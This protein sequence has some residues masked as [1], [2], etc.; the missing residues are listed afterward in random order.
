M[1]DEDPDG[2]DKVMT[3]EVKEGR[4]H[5]LAGVLTGLRKIFLDATDIRSDA[6]IEGTIETIHKDMVFRGPNVWIL[7]CSI[8]IASIGLDTNSTAVIIGAML[9]S[10]LMGPILA[11]G[12]C[13]G[14]NDVPTLRRAIRHFLVMTLFALATSTI[15][16]L[17]TPLGEA[18]TELMA[19]VRPTL[20][21]AAIAVFGGLAGIIGVSRRNRGN[22]IPG[23]AIA[24][25][26][27]PPLCTAGFGI[28]NGNGSFFFGAIY[29][30]SLNSVFIAISTVVIVRFLGFP[31][32]QF[33]D[34]AARR[35]VR[36]QLTA[37]VLVILIPST[38]I[39]VG[40]VKENLFHRRASDFIAENLL[41]LPGVDIVRRQV[42]YSDTTSLIDIVLSGDSIPPDLARQLEGRM[43][44]AQLTN[45]T[46]RIRQPENLTGELGRLSG[47]LRV[48]II[49][50]I[51]DRQALL[52][53]ERDRR[54]S[55]LEAE[56]YGDTIPVSQIMREVAVQYPMVDRLSFG[57][58]IGV[59]ESDGDE[60]A[61]TLDTIPTA[62]IEWQAGT[63]ATQKRAEGARLTEWLKVR[64]E[65]DTIRVVQN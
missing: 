32:V 64:L 45:T 27:M 12:L 6:N 14:V 4:S 46:L 23:V 44:A 60:R 57:R 8:F 41:G 58:V 35:K 10:P 18:Q 30:F 52:I 54:I 59:K 39:L 61:L 62:L 48:G 34:D 38:W 7:I 53:T 24:T 2:P 26:L 29:L 50:D 63:S 25:A 11:I 43:A 9:I 47:E 65:L 15:Y 56:L 42:I 22:V 19:R 5:D 20:L 55:E 3:T 36:L 31:F 28:A 17:I 21:D 1:R 13:I 16:F 37:F 49:E 51:Y 40:V 33:M